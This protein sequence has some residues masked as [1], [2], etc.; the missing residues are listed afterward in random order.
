MSVSAVDFPMNPDY[1]YLLSEDSRQVC[2]FKDN[3]Q[4]SVQAKYDIEFVRFR[5]DLGIFSG[6]NDSKHIISR[7]CRKKIDEDLSYID[8]LK[9]TNLRCKDNNESLKYVEYNSTVNYYPEGIEIVKYPKPYK[10]IP[11]FKKSELEELGFA[12]DVLEM[13]NQAD[14][15]RLFLKT[16]DGD[17]KLNREGVTV[18]EALD[19]VKKNNNVS[20][21]Q[22]LDQL[23]SLALSNTWDYFFTLTFN[24]N[25]V[26]SADRDQCSEAYKKFQRKLRDL[27]PS[28]KSLFIIE[29][30]NDEE[31]FHFHGFISG[32][33]SNY[34]HEAFNPKTNEPLYDTM[35]NRVYNCDLWEFGY[36]TCVC[37]P[38]GYNKLRV[39]NYIS[40]YIN[41]NFKSIPYGFNILYH[42]RL[43]SEAYPEGLESRVSVNVNLTDRE[44]SDI[45]FDYY[46]DEAASVHDTNL[47]SD[48]SKTSIYRVKKSGVISIFLSYKSIEE[49]S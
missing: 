5:A 12:V 32:N 23:Y 42:S 24:R 29:Y 17:Y 1:D 36:N 46:Y 47:L 10:I 44:I 49:S 35:R 45:L 7:L 33:L 28:M 3:I 2:M 31:H 39:C 15:S 41:K 26:D 9:D 4:D 8:L 22:T 48:V 6:H 13:R 19:M 16:L 20:R 37:L 27:D 18:S 40:K 14:R 34:I 21:K 11:Q 38:K 43:K 30:H 25:I